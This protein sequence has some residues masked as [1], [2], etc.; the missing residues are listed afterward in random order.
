MYSQYFKFITSKNCPVH[1][2]WFNDM[3]SAY[4]QAPIKDKLAFLLHQCVMLNY[5]DRA[6]DAFDI[7]TDCVYDNGTLYL[8]TRFKEDFIIPNIA[9]LKGEINEHDNAK[10]NERILEQIEYL[11][12]YNRSVGVVLDAKFC[13][14]ALGSYGSDDV[15]LVFAESDASFYEPYLLFVEKTSV[16]DNLV[17]LSKLPSSAYINFAR[18]EE[19]SI[20]SFSLLNNL[21]VVDFDQR[22]VGYNYDARKH[23]ELI[24]SLNVKSSSILSYLYGYNWRGWSINGFLGVL[25]GMCLELDANLIPNGSILWMYYFLY[26]KV[27]KWKPHASTWENALRTSPDII[28]SKRWV[29]S[30]LSAIRNRYVV[31]LDDIELLKDL[32]DIRD[33]DIGEDSLHEYLN[34]KDASGV[35]VE[36]YTGFKRSVFGTFEELD[37]KKSKRQSLDELVALQARSDIE[38]YA[39]LKNASKVS[40]LPMYLQ[41]S[42]FSLDEVLTG[43]RVQKA[44]NVAGGSY[45]NA[46]ADAGQGVEEPEGD[47]PEDE[48]EAMKPD[49][50]DSDDQNPDSD[51]ATM[52]GSDNEEME[53]DDTH[54]QEPLPV[55]S[56][57]R[58]VRLDLSPNE[59]T[60]TVLY[61]FELK[62][63]VDTLLA[64]P[65]KY[66]DAQTIVYLKKLKAFW[67]N[68]LSVQTLYH[69]LN[70]VV[71]VPKAYRIKKIKG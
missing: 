63:Y 1:S 69:V 61:R 62:A 12:N 67:W 50:P 27:F 23:L 28:I 24:Q 66:L 55:V 2:D 34:A 51:P 43:T 22:T 40:D 41:D 18:A 53:E 71:K 17:D 48:G 45:F 11:A 57:K 70:S 54:T 5:I 4:R 49:E 47:D 25:A 31:K 38:V 3:P 16:T 7:T 42:T 8:I 15:P 6:Y 26:R 52:P 58:G 46:D 44:K 14:A 36:M 65:P 21:L 37:F 35:S 10:V 39:S 33:K 30:L 56:D 29:M 64:N 13:I 9:A 68:C 32:L 59:S 20:P 60:D 19:A